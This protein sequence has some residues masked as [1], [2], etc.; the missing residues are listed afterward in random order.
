MPEIVLGDHDSVGAEPEKSRV[1]ERNEAGVATQ[2]IPGERQ[3][4]P[5]WH[6]SR[7]QQIIAI[8]DEQSCGEIRDTE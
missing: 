4:R 7:N 8:V 1:S 2:D 6:Q 5:D 3:Q